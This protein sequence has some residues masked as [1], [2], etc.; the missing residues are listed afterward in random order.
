MNLPPFYFIAYTA[1]GLFSF[2]HDTVILDLLQNKQATIKPT[3]TATVN[4]TNTTEAQQQQQQQQHAD[5]QRQQ[6]LQR[7]IP[8]KEY[9]LFVKS[10]S[11]LQYVQLL[12]EVYSSH[13][14]GTKGKWTA[15]A[16]VE[17]IK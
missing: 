13:R 16:V 6:L 7:T 1:V 3:V 8:P 11:F 17:S 14:W 9:N 4:P 2:Y 15:I 12:V 10:I 5:D